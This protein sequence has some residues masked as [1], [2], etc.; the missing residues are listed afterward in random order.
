MLKSSKISQKWK[1]CKIEK[2]LKSL[3]RQK[4]GLEGKF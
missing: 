1:L 2:I 3:K 4:Y